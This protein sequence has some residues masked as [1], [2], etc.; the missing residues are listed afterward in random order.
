L[1][2]GY[3]DPAGQIIVFTVFTGGMIPTRFSGIAMAAGNLVILIPYYI[4][5]VRFER[6]VVESRHPDVEPA[7]IAFAVRL[8]NRITYA[9]LA[10]IVLGFLCVAVANYSRQ[11]TDSR[12]FECAGKT[13][14]GVAAELV[15]TEVESIGP[16][17]KVGSKKPQH[18]P[19]Y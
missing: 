2:A 10:T 15:E 18:T 3:R 13:F 14:D 16:S 7:R 4:Y 12:S 19:T 6:R 5:T 8:M 17:N 1:P 11:T 9:A